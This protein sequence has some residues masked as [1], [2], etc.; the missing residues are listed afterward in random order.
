[1]NKFWLLLLFAVSGF[2]AIAQQAADDAMP[3]TAP[4][5]PVT[6]TVSPPEVPARPPLIAVP[7]SAP[8]PAALPLNAPVKES[9]AWRARAHKLRVTNGGLQQ[10]IS[11]T[12]DAA[13]MTLIS[14][15]S[16]SGLRVQTLNSKA[17]ELLAMPVDTRSTQKYVFVVTEMPPGTVTIKAT[18]WSQS[19]TAAVTLESVFQ[20]LRGP[21]I[22]AT[23]RSPR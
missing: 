22:T 21:Q 12:Y 23:Q 17:G 5:I 10:Q 16:Q 19:K 3:P 14:A 9:L 6:P 13:I 1:M 8:V 15:L 2:P 18:P 7:Q 4:A 11:A 20:A